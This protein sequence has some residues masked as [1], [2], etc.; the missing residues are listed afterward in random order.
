MKYAV[1][2]SRTLIDVGYYHGIHGIHEFSFFDGDKFVTSIPP[3]VSVRFEGHDLVIW[4]QKNGIRCFFMIKKPL[5]RSLITL[6][7]GYYTVCSSAN[8]E[9]P[10]VDVKASGNRWTFHPNVK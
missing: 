9:R 6:L 5:I 3:D 2:P 10:T 8:G 7:Y 4:R 1:E